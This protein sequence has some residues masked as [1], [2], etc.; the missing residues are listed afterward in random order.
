MQR[1]KQFQKVV[2]KQQKPIDSQRAKSVVKLSLIISHRPSSS[3]VATKKM[4]QQTPFLL[5]ANR[6]FLNWKSWLLSLL[7]GRHEKRKKEWK[8][9]TIFTNCADAVDAFQRASNRIQSTMKYLWYFSVPVRE[10]K[11]TRRERKKENQIIYVNRHFNLIMLNPFM[12]NLHHGHQ[13]LVDTWTLHCLLA[14]SCF[15]MY[16]ALYK[17]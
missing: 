4:W 14:E 9:K 5:S 15:L 11:T 13:R 10:L 12:L 8:K 3:L 7:R 17:S 2:F 1:L 6:R 16:L